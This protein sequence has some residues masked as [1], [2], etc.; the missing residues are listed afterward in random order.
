MRELRH[1]W[2]LVH[3]QDR[4]SR[5]RCSKPHCQYEL[6]SATTLL[7]LRY[8]F[9]HLCVSLRDVKGSL[10]H[11]FKFASLSFRDTIRQAFA[12]ALHS[13]FLTWMSLSLG[14]LDIF[15]RGCRPSQT[16]HQPLFPLSR[17]SIFIKNK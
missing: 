8:L 11:S 7:S 17:I 15:S 12:F 5:R 16:A 13:R 1:P 6:S 9:C 2:S 4:K 10:S 3:D 14:P